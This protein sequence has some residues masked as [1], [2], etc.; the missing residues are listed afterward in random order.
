MLTIFLKTALIYLLLTAAIRLMGKRQLGELDITEFV[1]TIL[2]SEIA[3]A[4]ITNREIPISHVIVS[5]ATLVAFEVISSY[6]II[7]IPIVKSLL[8]SRPSVI[9]S[10]GKLDIKEMRRVRISLEELICQVRQNGIFDLDEVDYAILEEN[11]KMSIIPKSYHRQPDKSELALP[12][13]DS[14]AMHIL[15]SDG[16]INQRNLSLLGKNTEWLSQTVANHGIIINDIFCMT[17][18]DAGK[19][20]IID[21]NG[22]SIPI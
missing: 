16:K 14:G 8:S 17:C 15:I 5:M 19:L 21:K 9:I 10:R 6:L 11:G 4:P 18:N 12:F 20:F 22:Q 2:L 7:K 3:S 1:I 13:D